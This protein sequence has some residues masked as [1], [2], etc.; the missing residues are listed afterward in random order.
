MSLKSLKPIICG[1]AAS[2]AAVGSTVGMGLSLWAAGLVAA[3]VF[4]GLSL[5]LPGKTAEEAQLDSGPDNH[6][7]QELVRDTEKRLGKL[8]GQLAAGL[9]D[10][11]TLPSKR[12]VQTSREILQQVREQP[13][14]ID[15]AYR[16]LT[17]YLESTL[18][19]IETFRKLRQQNA[20]NISV[21][22]TDLAALLERVA[23]SFANQKD[24]LMEDDMLKLK[25]EMTV[26]EKTISLEG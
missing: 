10:P 4:A 19:I 17:Y 11:I 5:A 15:S 7:L 1:C 21:T 9:P 3:G 23:T 2:L 13:R 18:T 25:T 22:E 20:K 12:I 6:T 14:N 8:T 16:Y 24:T 26:L